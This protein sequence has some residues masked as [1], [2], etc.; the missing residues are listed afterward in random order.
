[1]AKGCPHN[2]GTTLKAIPAACQWLSCAP[3]RFLE[4]FTFRVS[5]LHSPLSQS[6]KNSG[7][8]YIVPVPSGHR[9]L[10]LPRHHSTTIQVPITPFTLEST[11]VYVC[12]GWFQPLSELTVHPTP[13]LQNPLLHGCVF[14]QGVSQIHVWGWVCDCRVPLGQAGPRAWELLCSQQVSA[15]SRSL[16]PPTRCW[17]YGSSFSSFL[18]TF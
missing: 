8:P 3:D 7:F 2:Q 1:M 11:S 18:L 15:V 6:F 12:Q 17:I 16:H 4:P 13:C 10:P 9:P 14:C 5:L